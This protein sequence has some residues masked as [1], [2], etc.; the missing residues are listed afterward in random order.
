VLVA[1]LLD[2][3]PQAFDNRFQFSSPDVAGCTGHARTFFHVILPTGWG[4]PSSGSFALVRV[5]P[6]ALFRLHAMASNCGDFRAM[7]GDASSAGGQAPPAAPCLS[8]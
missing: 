2:L 4:A 8:R 3:S 5:C 6:S 1:K 7:D